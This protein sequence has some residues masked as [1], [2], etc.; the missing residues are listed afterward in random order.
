MSRK[1][2]LQGQPKSIDLAKENSFLALVTQKH[3]VSND[4]ESMRSFLKNYYCEEGHSSPGGERSVKSYYILSEHFTSSEHEGVLDIEKIIMK[5]NL[6]IAKPDMWIVN[7]IT[8][9]I[10]IEPKVP[11]RF[12]VKH[13]VDLLKSNGADKVLIAIAYNPENEER[14]IKQIR[15]KN[16]LSV[17]DGVLLVDYTRFDDFVNGEVSSND[18]VKEFEE[19]NR[20]LIFSNGKPIACPL[21]PRSRRQS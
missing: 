18:L 17:C 11:Q 7:G 12:K 1:S 15:N 9:A 13:K 21:P 8:K 20:S 3:H 19:Y 6:I 14:T 10:E 2:R 4:F 16:L 5:D